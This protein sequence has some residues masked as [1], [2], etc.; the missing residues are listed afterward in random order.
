MPVARAI[1]I[2]IASALTIRMCCLQSVE[3]TV[4]NRRFAVV[5]PFIVHRIE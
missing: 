1:S 2:P 5:S 3:Q 4:P